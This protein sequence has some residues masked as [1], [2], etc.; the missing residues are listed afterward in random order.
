[1]TKVEFV[2]TRIHCS[3]WMRDSTTGQIDSTAPI[4]N[5]QISPGLTTPAQ[6]TSFIDLKANLNSGLEILNKSPI[7]QLD[8]NH[9]AYDFD[10]DNNV[11][12]GGTIN[13]VNGV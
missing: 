12:D 5:I 6:K 9:L 7:Y 2:E 1:M 8:E 11:L 13:G 3:S 10:H 4:G